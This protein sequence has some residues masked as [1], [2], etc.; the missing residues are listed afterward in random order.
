MRGPWLKGMRN[1]INAQIWSFKEPNFLCVSA[2]HGSAHLALFDQHM[3]DKYQLGKLI[4]RGDGRNTFILTSS[5]LS[6][7]APHLQPSEHAI[8]PNEDSVVILQ[9]RGVVFMGCHNAIWEL[10]ERLAS[11]GQNPDHPKS[12]GSRRNSPITSLRMSC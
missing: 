6:H 5:A 2:T 10:G 3:W 4:G 7:D 9:R 12:I 11:I 1:S 8:F